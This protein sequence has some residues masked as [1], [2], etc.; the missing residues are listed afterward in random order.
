[1]SLTTQSLSVINGETFDWPAG[2]DL[3]PFK[4]I[5]RLYFLSFRIKSRQILQIPQILLEE[6]E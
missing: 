5:T 4:L 3:N 1:M 6:E 2:Q